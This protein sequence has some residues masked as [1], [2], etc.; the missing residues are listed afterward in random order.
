MRRRLALL[1][2]GRSF[3]WLLAAA[4]LG[5]L[6]LSL[7]YLLT[8]GL[9]RNCATTGL[10]LLTLVSAPHVLTTLY[11]VVDRQNLVG[12]PRP[13]MTIGVIPLGLMAINY[14]V[15]LTAPLWAV[16]AY[17]IAYIHV[18][19][20]H[21]GRQNLGVVTFSTRIANRRSMTGFERW[22]IMGGVVAGVLGAYRTF[23]PDLLLNAN[24]WPFDLSDID[25]I[26]SRLWYG[27]V[28]I[29]A[30][31]AP[32]TLGYVLTRRSQYR[33]LSA[34]LYL[35]CVFFFFPAYMANRP[36]YLFS[37]WLV[38]HGVQYLVFVAFHAAGRAR[39]RPGLRA[40]GPLAVFSGCLATGVAL[41]TF[42]QR[43]GDHEIMRL[44]I[45]TTT[46][47]TLAHYWIDQ[48]LWKFASAERREWLAQSYR[49]VNVQAT[50]AAKRPAVA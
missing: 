38:A 23:A 45:A 33:P 20:W 30:L 40:L 35:S 46:A 34:L 24:A 26:F 28:A 17:M 1:V 8:D 36:L 10:K 27:G 12:I 3:L 50:A 39:G 49:F 6:A 4:T 25:P 16:L 14:A 42:S 5:P 9:S 21:F 2:S 44:A 22:T 47:L 41:W 48:F 11:L 29:Y 15:L 43:V 31:L 32:L 19:M 18:S 13:A 37:S 7:L